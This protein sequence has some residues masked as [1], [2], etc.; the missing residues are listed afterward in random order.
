MAS[1][2]VLVVGE[3][4][5]DVVE[6]AGSPTVEHV[7][8]SPANVALGLGRLGLPT[9]LRTA[10]AHDPRG[11]HI[12]AHL[13]SSGVQIDPESWCLSATSTAVARIGHG[14]AATY[15]F[16]IDWRLDDAIRLGT[17]RVVHVGSVGCFLQ[18]GARQLISWLETLPPAVRV[19]FDPNIRPALLGERS[20][21]VAAVERIARVADMVK[22][23]DEDARWLYPGVGPG[24]VLDRMIALGA[25]V[26][27]VTHGGEGAVI[28]SAEARTT[29]KPQV[30]RT[31]DTIGAGDTF[32]AVLVAALAERTLTTELDALREIGE[33]ASVAASITVGRAGADLPTRA[34]LCDAMVRHKVNDSWRT[35]SSSYLC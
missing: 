3:A 10:L 7:G 24:D 20:E 13:V 28:A 9:R 32:Q 23:S 12:A 18:P 26:A 17:A 14:G 33:R 4:L 30:V 35:R 5:I 21:I 29:I 1:D 34:E 2:P 25:R 6:R 19:S 15:L 8:G 22:L 27:C 11:E 16:D 31:K